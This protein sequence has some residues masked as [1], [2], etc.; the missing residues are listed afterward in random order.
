MSSLH[1]RRPPKLE[2]GDLLRR[3]RQR[4]AGGTLRRPPDNGVA[5]LEIPAGGGGSGGNNLSKKK[6]ICTPCRCI[7]V[8]ILLIFLFVRGRAALGREA[9]PLKTSPVGAGLRSFIRGADSG[10]DAKLGTNSG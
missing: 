5:A 7:T 6:R 8:I 4:A 2:Q 9:W 10:N 3:N 1:A